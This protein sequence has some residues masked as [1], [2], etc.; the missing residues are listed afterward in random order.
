[1]GEGNKISNF[2]GCTATVVLITKNEIYCAN[3]GDSR[4][5][6]GRS[7]GP[8]M[9]EALSDDHKPENP[10]ERARIEAAGGF[11]EENR[12]NGSLN[13]SRSMGDFEYKSKRERP[14]TEQQVIVDPEIKKVARQAND[15]FI[16]LACDGI[17][18]CVTSEEGVERMRDALAKRKSTE[19]ISN[20]TEALF[21]NIIA[22]DILASA[23]VGTDNMTAI[24]LEFKK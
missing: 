3:A 18:D 19:P 10:G 16:L 22:G 6:L 4:T 1:M 11:V 23:G 2:T 14:Y 5:V 24:L 20:I 7:N 15:Q 9:C 17:W 12:V 21:D 13:L 8:K